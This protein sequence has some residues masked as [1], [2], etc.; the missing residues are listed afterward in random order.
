VS[1]G[2]SAACFDLRRERL[3][4]CEEASS[5]GLATSLFSSDKELGGG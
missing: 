5:M 3:E 1:V 4:D 2:L